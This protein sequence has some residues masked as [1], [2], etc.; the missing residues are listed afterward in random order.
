MFLDLYEL[1]SPRGETKIKGDLATN[2][3]LI[4]ML[5]VVVWMWLS[6]G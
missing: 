1:K 6:V 3:S 4:T 2:V 5:F